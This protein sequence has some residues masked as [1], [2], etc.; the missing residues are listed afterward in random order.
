MASLGYVIRTRCQY[1]STAFDTEYAP[2]AVV[3]A[4]CVTLW[5]SSRLLGGY[6]QAKCYW[7]SGSR[8]R[9]RLNGGVGKPLC[10]DC[11]LYKVIILIEMVQF[12]CNN[13]GCPEF[14]GSRNGL[15][16][17]LNWCKYPPSDN[18]LNSK[19]NYICFYC[20]KDL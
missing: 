11:C 15:K 4:T 1:K 12:H 7:L 5:R 16:G 6:D 8:R 3:P 9:K 19:G 20:Q 13:I 17:H 14:Y 10:N 18:G 2:F